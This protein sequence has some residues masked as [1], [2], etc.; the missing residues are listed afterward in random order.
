MPVFAPRIPE[1]VKT[2]VLTGSIRRGLLRDSL[3][4]QIEVGR[5]EVRTI[6]LLHCNIPCLRPT[7]A[8]GVVNVQVPES[9]GT[10]AS[11]VASKAELENSVVSSEPAKKLSSTELIVSDDGP[12]P[13]A[14]EAAS[15]KLMVILVALDRVTVKAQNVPFKPDWD[16]RVGRCQ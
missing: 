15:M 1:I 5:P 3:D 6:G 7:A 13:G 10:V 12:V 14:T 16:G 2:R 8:P 11:L 9:A 4:A